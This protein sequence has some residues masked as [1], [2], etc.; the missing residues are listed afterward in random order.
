MTVESGNFQVFDRLSPKDSPS[1]ISAA[2]ICRPRRWV[3]SV[4]RLNVVQERSQYI[5]AQSEQLP[6]WKPLKMD[7]F[8]PQTL[9]FPYLQLLVSVSTCTEAWLDSMWPQLL[10]GWLFF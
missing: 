2:C 3:N 8:Y 6:K 5:L 4:S 7:L 1:Q 9:D 10:V